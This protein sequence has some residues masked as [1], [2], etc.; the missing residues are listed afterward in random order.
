MGLSFLPCS[1]KIIGDQVY[2][3]S[4]RRQLNLKAF[5]DQIGHASIKIR[6]KTAARLGLK[7]VCKV[8]VCE[9]RVLAK[10]RRTS[11]N[12]QIQKRSNIPGERRFVDISY[13]K[14]KSL[15]GKD[16]HIDPH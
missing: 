1:E 16:T 12:K 5:H 8:H 10:M 7:L 4:P 9:D 13:I 2:L 14:K 11:I 3:I 15:K 6:K